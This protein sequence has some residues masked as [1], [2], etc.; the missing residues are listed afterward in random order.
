MLHH[1][2]NEDDGLPQIVLSAQSDI[3]NQSN[4]PKT[5]SGASTP[6]HET[7]VRSGSDLN[8]NLLDSSF[9][10][11]QE[12]RSRS[13]SASSLVEQALAQEGLPQDDSLRRAVEQELSDSLNFSQA[14]LEGAARDIINNF[15]KEAGA[16]IESPSVELPPQYPDESETDWIPEER[17]PTYETAAR[18]DRTSYL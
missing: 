4:T 5:V 18:P 6:Q 8:S 2:D 11:T 10:P 3:S 12:R 1:V 15:E 14:Q 17:P 13:S 16:S 7:K 9:P